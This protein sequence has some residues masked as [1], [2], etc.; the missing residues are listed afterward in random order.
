MMHY[1]ENEEERSASGVGEQDWVQCSPSLRLSHCPPAELKVRGKR[2]ETK[3][4]R[5]VIQSCNYGEE[6]YCIC[7]FP[8]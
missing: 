3:K 8:P 5:D 1:R 2:W 4:L 6:V 7:M